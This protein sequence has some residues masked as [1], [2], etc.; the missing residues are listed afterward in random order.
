MRRRRCSPGGFPG[1]CLAAGERR[2]LASPIPATVVRFGGI[3]GPGRGWLVE[4]A[5][6]GG[7]ALR[8]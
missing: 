4:R 1:E 2:M 5:R 6:R 3:Y 7:G 8:R